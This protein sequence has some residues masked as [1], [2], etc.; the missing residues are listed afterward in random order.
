MFEK[1]SQWIWEDLKGKYRMLKFSGDI[2]GVVP[3]TGSI[4]WINALGRDVLSDWR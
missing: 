1:G 4:G 2:D 3:T